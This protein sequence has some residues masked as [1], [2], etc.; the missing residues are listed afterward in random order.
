MRLSLRN[1]CS[2]INVYVISMAAIITRKKWHYFMI[3]TH[4]LALLLCIIKVF[5]VNVLNANK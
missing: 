5:I 1:S 4:I 3:R 2:M